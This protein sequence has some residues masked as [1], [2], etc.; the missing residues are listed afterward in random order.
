MADEENHNGVAE[1]ASRNFKMFI[2]ANARTQEQYD[3]E[4]G[5][6]KGKVAEVGM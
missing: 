2:D 5:K 3:Q 4:H 1:Y 6:A